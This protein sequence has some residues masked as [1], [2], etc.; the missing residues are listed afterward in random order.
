M[1]G[2]C[3]SSMCCPLKHDFLHHVSR[4]SLNILWIIHLSGSSSWNTSW[5]ISFEI[6]KDPYIF[7]FSFFKGQFKWMYLVFN[8]MLFP[9]FNPW[10]FLLFLLN[11]LFIASLAIFIDFFAA[12]QLPCSSLRNFSN[13]DISVFIIRSPF[14]RCLP[15]LS[16]NRVCPITTCLLLL[17][18]NSAMDSHSV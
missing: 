9:T 8:H 3:A 18:W 2:S 13:F 5:S 10:G 4:S 15:K 7:W 12:P 1:S 6:L 16:S 11:C 14:H 17:Y